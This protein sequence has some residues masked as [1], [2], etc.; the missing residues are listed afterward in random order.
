MYIKKITCESCGYAIHHRKKDGG[1]TFLPQYLANLTLPIRHKESE[2][3]TI[4]VPV[5]RTLCSLSLK[6]LQIF[7]SIKVVKVSAR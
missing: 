3:F 1:C 7:V 4:M 6:I 2:T 5:L